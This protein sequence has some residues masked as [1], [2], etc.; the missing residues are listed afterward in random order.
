M[1]RDGVHDCRFPNRMRR[2]AFVMMRFFFAL[3][4]AT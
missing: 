4:T 3:V 1:N 2:S